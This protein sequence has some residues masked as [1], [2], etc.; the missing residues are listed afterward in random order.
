MASKAQGKKQEI[1]KAVFEARRRW[2]EEL[3]DVGVLDSHGW[4]ILPTFF[5]DRLKNVVRED[6][7]KQATKRKEE[8]DAD[9]DRI[10]LVI[11]KED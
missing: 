6:Y 4:L 3:L 10:I 1:A 8:L 5:V 2:I 9:A 7:D 11:D